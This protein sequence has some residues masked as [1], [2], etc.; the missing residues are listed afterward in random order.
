MNEELQ[1]LCK[2]CD[3]SK[4]ISEFY[5]R[6]ISGRVVYPCKV[7][8]SS[9]YKNWKETNPEYHR[10]WKAEHPDQVKTHHKKYRD[11]QNSEIG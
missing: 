2:K 1:Y 6:K 3:S 4:P 11:K 8:K 9:Y 7:C 5:V 10:N